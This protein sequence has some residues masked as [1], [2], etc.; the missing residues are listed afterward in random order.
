MNLLSGFLTSL[1]AFVYDQTDCIPKSA[2]PQ[3][4]GQVKMIKRFAITLITLSSLVYGSIFYLSVVHDTKFFDEILMQ[5]N[6]M[7]T[8]LSD[9]E[10]VGQSKFVLQTIINAEHPPENWPTLIVH[11]QE[12]DHDQLFY[13]YKVWSLKTGL[14]QKDINRSYPIFKARNSQL[15]II[16]MRFGKKKMV[17]QFPFS[18]APDGTIVTGLFYALNELPFSADLNKDNQVNHQDVLLAKGS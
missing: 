11:N 13:F 1:N 9:M 6:R 3:D 4:E 16:N 8:H 5:I 15:T 2:N 18:K 14:T 10:L 7:T 17:L 12:K